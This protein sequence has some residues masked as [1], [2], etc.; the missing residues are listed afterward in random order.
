MPVRQGLPL[1]FEGLTKELAHPIY[2]CAVGL[3][4]IEAQKKNQRDFQNR[5]RP[6]PPLIDRI[7]SWF[8]Q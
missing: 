2:A 7:L 5:P 6:A 1:G 4:M 3:T 8:E